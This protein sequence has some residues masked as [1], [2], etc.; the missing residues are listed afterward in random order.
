MKPPRNTRH[1]V[2]GIAYQTNHL[3]WKRLA[4]AAW[5][6]ASRLPVPDI[7][8]RLDAMYV[9]NIRDALGDTRQTVPF[10]PTFYDRLMAPNIAHQIRLVEA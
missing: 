1:A 9:A 8:L 2:L 6:D 10:D 7:L 5:R 4:L 3:F